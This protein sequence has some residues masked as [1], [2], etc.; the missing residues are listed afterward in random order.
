MKP[1]SHRR[2]FWHTPADADGICGAE[3][4]RLGR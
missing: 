2:T 1:Q 3:P 4:G